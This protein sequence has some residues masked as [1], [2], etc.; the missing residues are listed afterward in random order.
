MSSNHSLTAVIPDIGSFKRKV[1]NLENLPVKKRRYAAILT[2][3]SDSLDSS[4]NSGGLQKQPSS[5][6]S[7]RS[8]ASAHVAVERVKENCISPS[9][10]SECLH[11]TDRSLHYTDR[12]NEEDDDPLTP[13]TPFG[14]TPNFPAKMYAM[15]ANPMLRGIAEWLPHGRSWRIVDQK[16]FEKSIL[17]IFFEHAKFSSFVR[18]ANGWGFR[19]INSGPDKNSYYHE[20]FLRGL[21]H[22]CKKLYRPGRSKKALQGPM[23]VPNLYKISELHPLP[24]DPVPD[25]AVL[26]LSTI[27]NGPKAKV[28]VAYR[29]DS[30]NAS[31]A[32]LTTPS[33]TAALPV[34]MTR[35]ILENMLPVNKI[36]SDS[37]MST[38]STSAHRLSL[39][40]ATSSHQSGSLI[41]PNLLPPQPPQSL[42]CYLDNLSQLMRSDSIHKNPSK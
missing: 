3:S 16:Q 18:Q 42:E 7:T 6:E 26:L 12:S 13:L 17:P 10:I 36:S 15:L 40:G 37:S 39:S 41:L 33:S 8:T 2:E 22:L 38:N 24:E 27:R 5:L 21:P 11:C 25:E 29:L 28:P 14:S 4:V 20:Y 23:D 19:R 9:P 35:E 30:S 32:E 31:D 34:P 1:E